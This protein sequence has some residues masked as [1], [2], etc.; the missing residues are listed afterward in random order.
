MPILAWI[1]P[2]ISLIFL[3]RPLVFPILLFSSIFLHWYLR[4]AFLSLLAIL[5]NSAFKWIYL[6]FSPL[7][8]ASLPFIAVCKASSD[9]HFAYLHFFFLGMALITAPAREKPKQN[10]RRG[11]ITFRI[12]PHTHQRVQTYLVCN[13]TQR[14]QRLRQSCAW[15]FP[16]EVRVSSGLLQGQWL[17]CSRLEYGISALTGAFTINPP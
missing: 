4:K 3:K 17:W 1:T 7:P 12:K 14:P 10:G 13:R 5:W 2:L 9:N 8:S 6:C 16:E 15:V 11:K